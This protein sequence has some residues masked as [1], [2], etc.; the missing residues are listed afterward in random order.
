MNFAIWVVAPDITWYDVTNIAYG[1]AIRTTIWV[2]LKWRHTS[3]L[4]SHITDNPTVCSAVWLTSKKI[5]KLRSTS[6]LCG[7]TTDDRSIMRE[8]FLCHDAMRD[9]SSNYTDDNMSVMTSQIAGVSMVCS[10]VCS[11]TNQ[12]K[13]QSSVSLAFVRGIHRWQ[14]PPRDSKAENFQFDDVI[15][16]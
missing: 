12:R 15:I 16:V 7:E 5:S 2:A 1:T 11:G 6:P 10:T 9:P 4:T 8:A 14:V 3:V 13:H